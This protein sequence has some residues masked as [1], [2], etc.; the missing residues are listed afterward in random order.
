[1]FMVVQ[2]RDGRDEAISVDKILNRLQN[3]GS[4]ANLTHINYQQLT[5]KVIEQLFSGI[6]TSKIDDLSA[7][8]CTSQS[9]T[10]LDY[11]TLASRIVVSNH[12]KNTLADFAKVV[13]ML[14]VSGFINERA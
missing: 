1:M 11:G 8:Q 3:L 13:K 2:K 7:E 14:N 10:H 4:Q 12:H 5:M 6:S 9:T